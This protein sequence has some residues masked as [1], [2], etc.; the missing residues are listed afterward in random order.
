M[1]SIFG[2]WNRAEKSIKEFSIKEVATIILCFLMGIAFSYLSLYFFLEEFYL[3]FF[4]VGDFIYVK[5]NSGR[6]FSVLFVFGWGYFSLAFFQRLVGYQSD[7]SIKK[8]T[9]SFIIAAV[10]FVVGVIPVNL[11]V[12]S[13][14]A[15]KGYSYCNW[16]TG[17]SFRAPDV[18]LKDESL[19]LQSGSLIR[20]DIDDFFEQHNQSGTSPTLTELK[21]FIADVKQAREG[22]ISGKR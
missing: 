7:L 1:I 12:Q 16:F 22:Y 3:L 4:N 11:A 18:W 6:L 13:N 14:L 10:V 2:K 17:A 8:M 9:K 21:T 5:E 15:L 20:S 19:C